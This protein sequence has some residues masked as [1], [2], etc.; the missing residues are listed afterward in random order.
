MTDISCEIEALHLAFSISGSDTELHQNCAYRHGRWWMAVVLACSLGL[1]AC[2]SGN[3]PSGGTP[4]GGT[5][6]ALPGTLTHRNDNARTGQNLQEVILTPA[7]VKPTSFGQLFSYPVDG[8][9]YAQPLYM[10]NVTIGGRLH[11]VVFVATAHD[12]VYAFDADNPG[13]TPLWQTS[14]INPAA[15]VT[16]VPSSDF[17]CSEIAPELGIISTPVIDPASGT[18]YVVAFT[19]E[20]GTFLYRLHALSVNTGAEVGTGHV[21][22]QASVPG[23]GDGNDGQ[24][25]VRFNA[26]QH[27]QRAALLLSNGMV[28]IAF[29]ANCDTPPF[30]GW[31][32]G[33]NAT[34][35]ALLATFNDT[36]NGS[37]GGIWNGGPT[38][39]TN[40]NVFVITGNGTFD[41]RANNDW[42][43]SFLKLAGGA[44]TVLDFFTPFNQAD[45]QAADLDPGSAAPVLLPDQPVGPPHLLVSAGKEGRIY[46]VNRDNMGQFHAGS[47]SQIV[48]EVTG[49]LAFDP[50]WGSNGSTPAYFNNTIYFAANKDVLKAFSLVNGLLSTSPVAQGP[51]PFG[52]LGAQLTTSANGSDNG[53]VWALEN[54]NPAVLHAYSAANVANELYN[55]NMNPARDMLQ[56]G[57]HFAVPTVANGKVYVGTVDRVSVFGQLP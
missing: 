37:D 16:S 14:F 24:G 21:V 17:P 44:L 52:F 3:T 25:N 2:N 19:K 7:N 11:N 50:T 9:V 32:L 57:D 54:N 13:N 20:N 56:Q 22:I 28:Y 31:L 23:T 27:K 33:Y 6:A 55:S 1:A 46:L 43:D 15:G 51:A 41:G 34:S 5:P 47:D 36:P 48:Q 40:G 10:P 49:Q 38:A 30:H 8:Q 45:L 4:S 29:A 39:D 18:L 26:F 42:G 12:S 53:I 35:L